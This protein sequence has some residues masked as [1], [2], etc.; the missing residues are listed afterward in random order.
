MIHFFNTEKH[1]VVE[2]TTSNRYTWTSNLQMHV[3]HVV[4]MRFCI[5]TPRNSSDI[6]GNRTSLGI[7]TF[8]FSV[9]PVRS[10]FPVLVFRARFKFVIWI[11]FSGGH[12]G[13]YTQNRS[14]LRSAAA[15]L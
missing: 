7:T 12:I 3:N 11:D 4:P 14:K 8:R 5:V 13:S 6:T 15:Y 2:L 9:E 10:S 1:Y